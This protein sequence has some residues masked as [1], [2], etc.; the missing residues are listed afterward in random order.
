MI[1][2]GCG[3]ALITHVIHGGPVSRRELLDSFRG[4]GDSALAEWGVRVA[5]ELDGIHY[6]LD[7]D[8][9]FNDRYT[10]WNGDVSRQLLAAGSDVSKI[11]IGAAGCILDLE[12]SPDG[13]YYI[14]AENVRKLQ[15]Y[16]ENG[17]LCVR[18][19]SSA[20][21]FD[22]I[23]ERHVTL[24]VPEGADFDKVEVEF[25]AGELNLNLGQLTADKLILKIGAGQVTGDGID[26][27]DKLEIA[28]GA[29][30]VELY[31]VQ[32]E[33]IEAEVAVGN[34]ELQGDIASKG[35]ITCSMG[36]VSLT[37]DG[38]EESY[39]YDI[40]VA[41]GNVSV[42]GNMYSSLAG[43]KVIRNGVDRTLIVEC[44]IGNID[45]YFDGQ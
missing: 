4:G 20:N 9:I 32:A 44:A 35:D 10:L 40:Q 29:G 31:Q 15:G 23:R 34:L 13:N 19:L 24:Y 39:N 41:A 43:D 36:N 7:D 30:T 28:V 17:T 6:D 42:G 26:V 11:D 22:D 2:A 45:I 5:E 33:K 38:T 12:V 27:A 18:T 25:G 37:L 3:L 1:G 8:V 16:T 21:T 14:E